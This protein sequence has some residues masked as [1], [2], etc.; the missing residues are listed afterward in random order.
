[1]K[2]LIKVHYCNSILTTQ[3]TIQGTSRVGPLRKLKLGSSASI[4]LNMGAVRLLA[5]QVQRELEPY[6]VA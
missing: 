4:V 3:G 5:S 6:G 2:G 1:M